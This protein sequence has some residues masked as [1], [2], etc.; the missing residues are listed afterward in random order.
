MR[1]LL[2]ESE[3]ARMEVEEKEYVGWR[4]K[5]RCFYLTIKEGVKT[6]GRDIWLARDFEHGFYEK[7]ELSVSIPESVTAIGRGAFSDTPIEKLVIPD[8]VEIIDSY[9]FCDC[10]ELEEITLPRALIEIGFN[11]FGGCKKLKKVD[12]PEATTKIDGS[13]WGCEN[14]ESITLPKALTNIGGHTFCKCRKLK[15]IE[16][17]ETVT[18]IEGWAFANC[19]TLKKV[20]IPETVLELGDDVFWGCYS[21]EE[22]IVPEHILLTMDKRKILSDTHAKVIVSKGNTL[23]APTKRCN[24]ANAKTEKGK[25]ASEVSST[26]GKIVTSNENAI[27]PTMRFYAG[28]PRKNVIVNKKKGPK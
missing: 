6:I 19:T 21:L 22:I 3:F 23:S 28:M 24:G 17:P 9:A 2:W 20:I 12:I 10:K 7:R 4:S 1:E 14:L 15:S 27:V 13:F 26:K 25:K 18:K 5:G 8:S 16:I 11:A